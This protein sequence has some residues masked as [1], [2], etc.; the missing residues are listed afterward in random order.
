M[1]L[2]RTLWGPAAIYTLT[3]SLAAAMPFLMLPVLTR[4]L[5]PEDYGT[6]AMFTIT[7]SVFAAFTGLSVPNSIGV[8]YFDRDR[9]DLPRY[10]ATCLV[11]TAIST[12]VVLVLVVAGATWL[13]QITHLDPTWLEVAVMVAAAQAVIMTLLSLWQSSAQPWIFGAFRVSQAT[14]D[15]VLSLSLVL[16]V[17]LAWQ[18]RLLG[19][20]I[21]TTGM[22][23]LALVLLRRGRW[24]AGGFDRDYA[25]QALSFGVPLIPHVIGGLL[26]AIVDRVMIS[27]VL[28]IGATGIYM[29]AVQI[30]AVL[31]LATDSFNK[32]YAPWLFGRLR[33]ADPASNAR[34]VRL[35]YAYFA[36][37]VLAALCVGLAAPAILAIIA[38]PRFQA[39]APVVS[40][41]ALGFAF[42]GMYFMV[43]NYVF[44]AGRTGSLAAITLGCG[45][46]NVMASYFLVHELGVIGAARAYMLAQGAL[47]LCTWLLAQ[48]S[49]PMPWLDAILPRGARHA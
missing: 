5:S 41:I 24:S 30:G 3:N 34:I 15:A 35:T 18:G 29:V 37:V 28:D 8:R 20:A 43:T 48:R 13:S 38:G 2:L 16:V 11:I 45:A 47:F 17:G 12:V 14:L 22:G 33:E 7:V 19:I 9:I 31:G 25:R 32:A 6:V 39:A 23:V 36:V 10:V 46:F 44:F 40:Y 42:G 26:I 27:T 49:H 4:V 21:A 1:S